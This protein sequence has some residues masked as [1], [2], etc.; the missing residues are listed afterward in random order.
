MIDLPGPWRELTEAAVEVAGDQP[1]QDIFQVSG[2][3]H[4]VE[5]AALDQGRKDRPVFSA[6]VGAGEQGVLAVERQRPDGALDDVVVEL[7]AAVV[8]EPGQPGPA[9]GGVADVSVS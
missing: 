4:A 7:D 8:E 1:G 3:V 2:G 9:G 5:F 6:F